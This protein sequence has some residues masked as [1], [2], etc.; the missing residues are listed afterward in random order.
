MKGKTWGP[1]TVHQKERVHIRPLVDMTDGQH[2]QWSRSAPNLEKAQKSLLA[3]A[4]AAAQQTLPGSSTMPDLGGS[5]LDDASRAATG[6]ASGEAK[7]PKGALE[8]HLLNAAALL[9]GVALGR[10]VR[11]GGPPVRP[12]PPRR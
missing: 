3:A 6:S 7:R 8:F 9:A 10:D 12:S 2:R 1:S 5:P 4:A 11:G